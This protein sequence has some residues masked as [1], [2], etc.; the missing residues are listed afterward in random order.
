MAAFSGGSSA[1]RCATRRRSPRVSRVTVD[2]E[3]A[4]S[5][6]RQR[7]H[8]ALPA[9]VGVEV[10]A[11]Q[12]GSPQPESRLGRA[13][14]DDLRACRLTCCGLRGRGGGGHGRSPGR[15]VRG[16]PR[17]V[18][19]RPCR[20]RCAG[21]QVPAR[22]RRR[23]VAAVRDPLKGSRRSSRRTDPSPQSWRENAHRLEV[24]EAPAR[25]SGH[26]KRVVQNVDPGGSRGGGQSKQR[27]SL[28]C[29]QRAPREM[30]P[31]VHS[32]MADTTGEPNG[33]VAIDFG[34]RRSRAVRVGLGRNGLGKRKRSGGDSSSRRARV[35]PRDTRTGM[36]I[37]AASSSPAV[38]LYEAEIRC[39]WMPLRALLGGGAT[40]PRRPHQRPQLHD[41]SGR[42]RSAPGKCMSVCAPALHLRADAIPASAPE[43]AADADERP[44]FATRPTR[45]LLEPNAYLPAGAAASSSRGSAV[46][47]RIRGSPPATDT[48]TSGGNR[49]TP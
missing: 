11:Q 21:L 1:A 2:D 44:P 10:A 26:S 13:V 18:R 5:G 45:S 12:A 8:L 34:A 46:V 17:D 15:S 14:E 30:C 33:A 9:T 4:A 27:D 28:Q 43:E 40:A 41:R 38:W 25:G 35:K 24:C 6:A 32:L 3:H 7:N 36:R 37:A 19:G 23:R 39:P 20:D 22:R 31:P 49:G 29:K 16:C 47:S 48:R 42:R